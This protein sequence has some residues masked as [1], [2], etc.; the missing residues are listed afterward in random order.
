MLS[1][2]Q[3]KI[4]DIFFKKEFVSIADLRGIYTDF[5]RVQLCLKKFE[6]QGLI[7][8]IKFGEWQ[9]LGSAIQK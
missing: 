1:K 4:L 8:M 7:K 5:K 9:Y 6:A 2:E 3:K